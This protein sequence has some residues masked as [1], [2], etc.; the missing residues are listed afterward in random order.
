MLEMDVN[1][2]FDRHHLKRKYCYRTPDSGTVADD[3]AASSG[4]FF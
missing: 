3:P 1:C 4:R 2:E